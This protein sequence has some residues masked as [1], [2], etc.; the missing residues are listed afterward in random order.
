MS[1]DITHSERKD[2]IAVLDYA[3]GVAIIWVVL[4]HS[5]GASIQVFDNKEVSS[6]LGI[7]IHQLCLPAVFIFLFITGYF[8]SKVPANNILP[9]VKRSLTRI[10]IP[11]L[12]WGS[13]FF[14]LI[15]SEGFRDIRGITIKVLLFT[16]VYWYFGLLLLYFMIGPI[17]LRFQEASL[18]KVLMG[19]LLV[20]LLFSIIGSLLFYTDFEPHRYWIDYLMLRNPLYWGFY[21]LLGYCVGRMNQLD[22]ALAFLHAR[23]TLFGISALFVCVI[24]AIEWYVLAEILK[25]KFL[26]VVF[27]IRFSSQL[28]CV[29]GGGF[30]LAYMKEIEALNLGFIKRVLS[31]LGQHSLEIYLMHPIVIYVIV[32]GIFGSYGDVNWTKS[33]ALF[34]GL[35]IPLF[36]RDLVKRVSPALSIVVWGR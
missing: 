22:H 11:Y 3:R 23:K 26:E 31:T 15:G 9:S 4:A 34:A 17:I 21:F 25:I 2:R 1:S 14:A 20:S 35:A 19:S 13:L 5:I 24:A 6:F 27:Q 32:Q 36:G 8:L 28:Y 12:I 7:F 18:N 29:L 33:V 16:H 10:Y 30:V